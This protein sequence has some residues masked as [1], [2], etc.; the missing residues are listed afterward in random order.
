MDRSS[1]VTLIDRLSP[2]VF[3]AL[4]IA[5]TWPVLEGIGARWLKF[6]ESYSHGYLV[7]AVSLFFSVRKWQETRPVAGFYP[8]WFIPLVLSA[9]LYLIGGILLIEAF[10]QV[11]LLPLL[12]S[13]LLV[14]WGWKQAK[15]FFLPIGVL[16][17]T[18]PIWDYLAW[19]LQLI[20]VAV[21]QFIL[22]WLDIEFIV[23]GIIVYFPG[24]GAFEIAHGCSGLR[25][26]LVGLTLVVLYSELNLSRLRERVLLCVA[27][28]ILALVA[29]WIRVFVIIY[30]GY[31]SNMTSSLIHEHDF[32]GWWVFAGTLVPLFLF[33]RW[34]ERRE[35]PTT[36]S[37][38]QSDGA[39]RSSVGV[40]LLFSLS[41][42]FIALSWW[43]AP[44]RD[45]NSRGTL[46]AHE[47]PFA[48]ELSEWLPMFQDHLLGW[49]PTID[50]PDRSFGKTFFL[51]GNSESGSGNGERVFLGLYSY[52]YQRPGREV[53][54]Y[55]NR[56]YVPEYFL[57]N[58]TFSV[59]V[60][61]S[62]D[63]AGMRLKALGGEREIYVAYGYYVEGL[64]ETNDLEAKLAQLPGIFNSRTDASLL[65]IGF[66][67]DECNGAER[68]KAMV[69][70][71]KKAAQNYLDRLYN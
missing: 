57:P 70:G 13:G 49:Q 36:L 7:L 14:L 45:D 31:E 38:A 50:R 37:R 33:A 60:S 20:T 56:L 19:Y 11:S 41:V 71:I 5:G 22:S 55:R 47:N 62:E 15:D 4:F 12:I 40:K 9:F 46:K 43:T 39:S 61:P 6:D 59:P 53:V 28:V 26:L 35:R 29:N 34:L 1:E 58:V 10:Q 17:F 23:E 42:V 30:V 8:L 2:L 18:I 21:N 64:W 27:G 67:C 16:L 24:V 69:P 51:R 3:L 48:G 25:Y 32:F 65:V 54:Q 44:G 63:L 66:V 68:L 52:D